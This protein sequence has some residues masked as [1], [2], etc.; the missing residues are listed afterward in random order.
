MNIVELT[1]EQSRDALA[2]QP[3]GEYVL[4]HEQWAAL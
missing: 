3:D 4:V 1:F 2:G